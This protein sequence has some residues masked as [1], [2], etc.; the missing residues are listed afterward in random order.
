MDQR[1]SEQLYR[2]SVWLVCMIFCGIIWWILF[3][4]SLFFFDTPTV[5]FVILFMT[6]F[7]CCAFVGMV[8]LFNWM[9]NI[10]TVRTRAPLDMP[11]FG[12]DEAEN[13]EDSEY[14]YYN[15]R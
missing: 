11:G 15:E 8:A 13:A 3:G 14:L 6:I 7:T 9:F 2:S 10:N 1:P 4:L 5:F 12:F